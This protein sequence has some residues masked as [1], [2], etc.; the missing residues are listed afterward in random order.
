MAEDNTPTNVVDEGGE[1]YHSISKGE[2][3]SKNLH[4]GTY[5]AAS[6]RA[7]QFYG[8]EHL[9][10]IAN[11]NLDYIQDEANDLVSELSE[12]VSFEN[13][14]GMFQ[15]TDDDV[16]REVSITLPTGK[17]AR[18]SIVAETFDNT[19]TI[20]FQDLDGYDGEQIFSFE[21]IDIDYE[22]DDLKSFI[23]DIDITYDI[24][25]AKGIAEGLLDEIRLKT[26]AGDFNFKEGY[27]LYKVNIKPDA[28]VVNI[29]DTSIFIENGIE[30]E[31][32]ADMVVGFLERPSK[33][34]EY[35]KYITEARI[36]N[37]KYEITKDFTV[38]QALEDYFTGA[39]VVGYTND[40][41]DV[42]SKSYMFL[43][44]DSYDLEKIDDIQF[45]TE[46]A[47]RHIKNNPYVNFSTIAKQEAYINPQRY[48]V[49]MNAFEG[50]DTPTSITQ[51]GLSQGP[52]TAAI[53]DIAFQNTQLINNLPVE[54]VVKDRWN[55][56]VKS[57]YR[58]LVTPGG[59]LDA[60]DVW[61]FG[62][63]GLMMLAIAYKE[64][65]EIPTIF[66]RTATNMFNNMTATYNIPPVP[67]EE[68]DLD[69]EFMNTV[70]ETGEKVMPT[71]IL[72][73]KVQEVEVDTDYVSTYLPEGTT[74]MDK[75]FDPYQEGVAEVKELTANIK[76][77]KVKQDLLESKGIQEEKMFKKKRPK[78]SAGG[79]SGVKIL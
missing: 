34:D 70:L 58:N 3:P 33:S 13:V 54:Q 78:K 24:D 76:R 6:D 36:G 51:S 23:G 71:D 32:S 35:T 8:G 66:S 16:I 59:V 62:V 48:Q 40:V 15:I 75:K 77:E 45:N 63:M 9:Y 28:N 30:K 1:L 22:P 5:N 69:Y 52:G 12:Q 68:Y 37:K 65:D 79:G 53:D 72:I 21:L 44:E 39:D 25:K 18:F 60:V 55:N 27:D 74:D 49:L 56:L 73:K 47:E 67:L 61:E 20:K 57:R 46:V 11:D 14:D 38:S 29:P 4:A 7:S 64:Y 41:E 17:E 2:K 26:Q 19:L 10:K 31:I 42:G 50:K 43:N